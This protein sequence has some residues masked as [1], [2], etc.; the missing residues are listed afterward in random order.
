[1]LVLIDTSSCKYAQ[2]S[3]QN[4]ALYLQ[5]MGLINATLVWYS[6]FHVSSYPTTF[7]QIYFTSGKLQFNGFLQYNI[8]VLLCHTWKALICFGLLYHTWKGLICFGVCILI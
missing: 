4:R 6:E 2:Y 8:S 7:S 1:M 5:I 3:F